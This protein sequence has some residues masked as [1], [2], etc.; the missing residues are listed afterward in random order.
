M[1]RAKDVKFFTDKQGNCTIILNGLTDLG[2]VDDT[3]SQTRPLITIYKISK[4]EKT[5]L[6]NFKDLEL[7]F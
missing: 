6:K 7:L 1:T 4:K 5:V 2:L 3:V